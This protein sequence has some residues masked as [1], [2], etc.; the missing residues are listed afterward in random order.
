MFSIDVL[1]NII[2][3]EIDAETFFLLRRRTLNNNNQRT[4]LMLFCCERTWIRIEKPLKINRVE[5][6][7][8]FSMHERWKETTTGIKKKVRNENKSSKNLLSFQ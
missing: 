7:R 3:F 5:D 8:V 2:P 4:N 1:T 6:G